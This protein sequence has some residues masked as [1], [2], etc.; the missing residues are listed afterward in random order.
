MGCPIWYGDNCAIPHT[1][2]ELTHDVRTLVVSNPVFGLDF[3]S[4]AIIHRRLRDA[5]AQGA[6]VLL[7][8]EDLDELLELSD[9]ILVI[10]EGEISF[11]VAAEQA[12]RATSMASFCRL[13]QL[14]GVMRRR[15][16]CVHILSKAR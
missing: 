6:A 16:C 1:A 9:R 5:R 12:D 10:H 3:A 13:W 4:V 14:A 2:R 8:S 11:Q 7:L 15:C